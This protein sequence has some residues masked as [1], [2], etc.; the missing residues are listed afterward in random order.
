MNQAPVA[1]YGMKLGL[2]FDVILLYP[3]FKGLQKGYNTKPLE[4]ES[5]KL[6]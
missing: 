3:R 4:N 5:S 1:I 2:C 6:L